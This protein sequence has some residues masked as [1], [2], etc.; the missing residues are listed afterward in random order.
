MLSSRRLGGGGGGGS[1]SAVWAALAEALGWGG[2]GGGG[3]E[4]PHARTWEHREHRKRGARRL[5]MA[6]SVAESAER[7][8]A[9][10]NGRTLGTVQR[11]LTPRLPREEIY[12]AAA[13]W[14]NSQSMG[15]VR[16]GSACRSW[17]KSDIGKKRKHN[18]DAFFRDDDLCL[19]VVADGMG[20]HAAGDV[21][22]AEAVDAV[23]GMVKRGLP[24]LAPQAGP[25]TELTLRTACRLVESSIQAAT[26][27]IFGLAEQDP[28]KSGMGTTMSVMLMLGHTMV[29]GQVGDSRIYKLTPDR[30]DQI[31]EDHTLIAW[32]IK[33][34]IITEEEARTSPHRNVITR[35]VGNR[36]YVEADVQVLPV[37]H[38]ELYLLCS[39]GLHGY[40][41]PDELSAAIG[42]GVE[43]AVD[44][45]V[46]EANA[47]G[48][49]DN[50][51]AVLVEIL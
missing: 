21:A 32:Q 14:S 38:G 36:E 15:A 1:G 2:G 18:E 24:G 48:G 50:I 19:Y 45:L 23:Y 26:Y 20:G 34:G 40:F 16:A 35:A 28:G 3:S 11:R 4:P 22:S 5:H 31:T 29:T 33:Q 27:M 10:E 9:S 39:D 41:E 46:D 47:R 44:R 43:D 49:K 25:V 8:Q 12:E 30:A 17:G 6:P 13:R 51:T 42:A 37:E 7:G